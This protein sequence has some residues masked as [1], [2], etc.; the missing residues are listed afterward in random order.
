MKKKKE[1]LGELLNC[2]KDRWDYCPEGTKTVPVWESAIVLLGSI[3][4]ASAVHV[5]IDVLRDSRAGFDVLIATVRALGKI[6]DRAA[7][8]H[9]T[10]FLERNKRYYR[11]RWSR[12]EDYGLEKLRERWKLQELVR[13]RVREEVTW[14]LELALAEALARL[15]SPQSA[16]VQRY[17]GDD[18]TYVRS[19]ARKIARITSFR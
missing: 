13:S 6:G 5:L 15:D 4:D 17:L 19:Y 9:L 16:T 8:P 7:V 1:A 11:D 3:G 12:L 10:K 18:R 14:Q 2:V